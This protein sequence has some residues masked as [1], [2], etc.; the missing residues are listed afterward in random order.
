MHSVIIIAIALFCTLWSIAPYAAVSVARRTTNA[1]LLMSS[2][3]IDVLMHSRAHTTTQ[4]K[5]YGDWLR[6]A[7]L[8]VI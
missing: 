2:T 8:A 5:Q 1:T 6:H 3:D 4:T 7:R